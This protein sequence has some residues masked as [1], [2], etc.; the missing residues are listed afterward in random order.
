MELGRHKLHARAPAGESL[1]MRNGIGAL[2]GRQTG[3]ISIDRG[4]GGEMWVG[5]RIVKAKLATSVAEGRLRLAEVVKGPE[6]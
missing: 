4:R 1:H 3:K 6:R 2:M 5:G